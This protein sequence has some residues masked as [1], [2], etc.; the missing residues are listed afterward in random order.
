MACLKP[1][2]RINFV[3]SHK[4]DE[5][6]NS[7]LKLFKKL[8]PDSQLIKQFEQAEAYVRGQYHERML[9]MILDATCP[10]TVWESRGK[11][12]HKG[13]PVDVKALK[14]ENTKQEKPS[15]NSKA[16]TPKPKSKKPT[17]KKQQLS[18]KKK[19]AQE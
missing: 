15:N 1:L 7:D 18:D 2:E 3:A 14:D 5:Y 8:Y 12:I 11:V 6:Y 19:E 9:L 16:S 10:E 13:K 17:A 4:K